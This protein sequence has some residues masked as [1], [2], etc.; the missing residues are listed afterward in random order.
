MNKDEIILMLQ[1]LVASLQQ[2]LEDA[3]RKVDAL[4]SEVA[5]LKELLVRKAEEEQK[6]RNIVKGLSK[7]MQNKSEKQTPAKPES[8]SDDSCT[9]EAPEAKPRERTNYGARRMD[10]YVTEV[11]HV[12]VEPDDPRFDKERARWISERESARYI[13]IPM[14]FI[15]RI[16]HV[17]KYVQDGTVMEG[18]APDA[19]FL[20]SNYDGSF[21]AGIAQLRSSTP[22]PWSASSA[23][24]RR[25]AS[26]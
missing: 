2:Q 25:T 21:I 14:R 8:V 11:E 26:A 3:N 9:Q 5:E 10:H 16:Y 17:N 1:Q 18:K 19:P 22:C 23:T 20:G 6:Q 7:I 13:L 4:L 15:K 24:S 12:P